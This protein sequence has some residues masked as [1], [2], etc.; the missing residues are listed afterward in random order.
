[1]L[2]LIGVLLLASAA[3][4]GSVARGSGKPVIGKPAV[5]PAQPQAGK[6]FTVTFRVTDTKTGGALTAGKMVCDPSIAGTVIPHTE[7]FKAGMA[8]LSFVVPADAGGKAL[9]VRLTI[10]TPKG[11]A[12]RLVMFAVRAAPTPS[13]AIGDVSAPEGNSGTTTFSFPVRL[14]APATQTVTVDFKTSD[15]TAQAPSDYA[16]S[17]G[18]LTFKVG[19]QAKPITVSVV[20]DTVM[21]PDESFNVALSNPVN[22]TI[23]DGSA[24][25]TITND[26][27]AVPVT[28]GNYLSTEGNW[29]YLTVLANRTVTGFR[30]NSMTEDCQPGQLRIHGAVDW[31]TA[32][33]Y[34]IGNDG[35]FLANGNWSGSDKQGDAEWTAESWQVAGQFTTATTVTGTFT[36]SDEL[37]YKGTHYRCSTGTLNYSATLQH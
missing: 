14:S 20:A 23:A 3:T 16:T 27:L 24:T 28:A 5:V 19:E 6:R 35:S 34:P 29:V 30:T 7:S 37:N 4:G 13:I 36:L 31:G 25:G 21:E 22:A 12:T 32:H 26:D 1:M 15:G 2:G 17:S 9:K 8:R 10:K 33:A 11:S 18:T